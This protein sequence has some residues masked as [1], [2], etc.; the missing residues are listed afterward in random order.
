MENISKDTT[1]N[2]AQQYQE[3]LETQKIQQGALTNMSN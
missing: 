2:S 3:R 1:Q